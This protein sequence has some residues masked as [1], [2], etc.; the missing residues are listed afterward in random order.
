MEKG[1][2]EF[3]KTSLEP[4]GNSV[5]N[6]NVQIFLFINSTLFSKTIPLWGQASQPVSKSAYSLAIQVDFS[7]L[8]KKSERN[9]ERKTLISHY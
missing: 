8:K 3:S 4:G 6:G 9:Y 7:T 5:K 1:R 2:I